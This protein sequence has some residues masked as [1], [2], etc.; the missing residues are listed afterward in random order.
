MS[1][2]SNTRSSRFPVLAVAAIGGVGLA[3][4]AVMVQG[5]NFGFANVTAL[6][7]SIPFLLGS[8]ATWFVAFLLDRN[9]HRQRRRLQVEFERRTQELE[10]TETRF[11]EYTRS[12]DNWFWETDVE[13]RF[14][15]LSSHLFE[16][17]GID[18]DSML[19]KR[20]TEIRLDGDDPVE[21]EAWERHLQCLERHEVFENFRYRARTPRGE[22]I[23]RTS[24][25][26]FFDNKGG[27]LG[28]RGLA[29][30]ITDQPDEDRLQ[31]FGQEPIYTAMTSLHS[32]FV[33]FDTDDR[34]VTCNA[35]YRELY[36]EVAGLFEPGV[37]FETICRAYADT[38]EF[39][40]EAD[41]SA[42]IEHR[43]EQHRNPQAPFDQQLANGTWIRIIDQRLP[44]GGVVGLRIDITESKHVEEEFENAQRM[45]MVGSY[46]WSVPEGRIISCSPELAQI[47]G[48][49]YDE[50]VRYGSGEQAL[51]IH[52]HDLDRVNEAYQQADQSGDSYRV[53][54]RVVRPGGEI[55]NVVESGVASIV[56]DGEVI[57]QFGSLQDVTE[58][59]RAEA[60][61]EQAQR[62]ANV[63]S[64]RWDVEQDRYITFS[65]ELARIFGYSK[66]QMMTM[67][68]ADFESLPLEEDAERVGAVFDDF[69]RSG[70]EFAFECRIR[71]ANDGEIRNIVERG[72]ATVM[73]DGKVI[74]HFGTVQDVTDSRRI[75]AELEEA[76]RVA[77]TGSFRWNVAEQRMIS[78]SPQMAKIFGLTREQALAFSADDFERLTLPEDRKRVNRHYDNFNRSGEA[79]ELERRIRRP[80]GQVRTI[81][82]RGI[83]TTMRA[84]RVVEQLGT[85]Q[86][87]TASRLTEA[88]LE[89]AQRIASIGSFRWDVE[90]GRYISVSDQM[91]R[92]FGYSRKQMINL[93]GGDLDDLTLEE[94]RDR[95]NAIYE[96]F[97]RTGEEYYLECRIRRADGEIRNI[98]ERGVAIEMREGR[99][100]EQFGTVQDVTESR[101]IEAELAQAQ[102][103]AEIGSFRRD[104]ESGRLVFCSPE[105]AR[106][107]GRSAEH[108][109]SLD[110]AELLNEVHPE[111][112]ERV[113]GAFDTS[114]Q[115]GG[116]REISYRLLLPDGEIRHVI[117]RRDA[118]IRRDGR[119]VEQLG[120]LQDITRSKRIEFE[121]E[122]AQALAKIGSF[123]WDV[124]AGE[125]VSCSQQYLNIYGRSFAE[126]QQFRESD[127]GELV[128][129]DDL[130]RLLQA[131]ELTNVHPKVLEV[132]YRIL[133]PDGE[134]RYVVERLQAS[135]WRDGRIV[136]Q[137]GT[138]QDITDRLETELQKAA[139][140]TMLE[141]AIENV[142]GGFLVVNAAG[143]IERFNR[144]FFDLYPEQQF[145]INEGIPLQRFIDYGVERGVYQ[146]ALDDPEGWKAQRMRLAM[147]DSVEYTEKMADG[148]SI[149]VA[150]RLQADGSRVGIHVDVTE[151]ESAREQA[152]SANA[153]KSDFLASMSHELR[154]PMH[155]ILSFAELGLK[156]IDKIAPDKMRQYLENIQLS[157]T[158]LLYLLN[159]LLDLSKL[160][161]GKMSMAPGPVN[162]VELLQA[163]I[164][165][166]Q[167][168][169]QDKNLRCVLET[170]FSGARCVCDRH[171]VMQVVT[172]ILANAVKYSPEGGE[173]RMLLR[174]DDGNF[175]LSVADQGIGI[176][177]DELDRVFEKFHQSSRS[178]EIPGGTG[179]GLAIC[180]EIVE[181]HHGRIWAE[182]NSDVGSSIHV[183]LPTG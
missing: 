174:R 182:N 76:Q 93:T 48:R 152:E 12:A 108:L 65:D 121:L 166:Q 83:A 133:R 38:L 155:G 116:Q 25:K 136:E 144:K 30:D 103:V 124:E 8:A 92:I 139:S 97:D 4:V 7:L 9:L 112:R 29:V 176:P 77:E 87:V 74:E 169:L 86:D 165:E 75:E 85:V 143:T 122:E 11:N 183:E 81:V 69:Y 105:F 150:S 13:H 170:G 28:Y 31:P 42:F 142:P 56:R 128:H 26:P 3:I 125:L 127:F 94:D 117:E 173:I 123:T 41:R 156:R 84:G 15:F 1:Q 49:P 21:S 20:R 71:R 6:S 106:I 172:N 82:E 138:L 115:A 107:H 96:K 18:P 50:V 79:F 60:E 111:D 95:V 149:R 35:R 5:L 24:G 16:A 39:D 162:L 130:D 146:G 46:R 158:R 163:C 51:W 132:E 118:S 159:D 68:S 99:V 134:V 145:F 171:R 89:Q 72:V 59:R 175:Q 90:N 177:E 32:G 100:I 10:A 34:L 148:R 180:R 154:T 168:R 44:S 33:L 36:P 19:G 70:E 141:A 102:R 120:T 179:L 47:I 104:V 58:T 17:T 140:E 114:G 147:S 40:S 113:M 53:E 88:E 109:L 161:A 126:M 131:Y 57:E 14:V 45:A 63:G 66:D 137:I 129:A 98:V 164:D 91:A 61:L 135:A 43:L 54:F 110:E 181:L 80:D 67:G 23:L 153:A 167:L 62:I 151:L 22:R 157:G 2:I 55:R 101:R 160:E 73:L 78:C 27:F 52:P 178:R 119:V 64:F 37:A